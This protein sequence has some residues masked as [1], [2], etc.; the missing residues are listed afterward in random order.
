[1]QSLVTNQII[2]QIFFGNFSL[3]K[4]KKTPNKTKVKPKI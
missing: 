2:F 4:K 3:K 1:M